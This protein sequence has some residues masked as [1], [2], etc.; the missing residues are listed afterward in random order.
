MGRLPGY[1]FQ[2]TAT[3][4]DG[5]SIRSRLIYAF[6]KRTEYFLDCQSRDGDPLAAETEAGCDQITHSFRL[7]S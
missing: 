5:T 4:A 2:I 6:R 7:G 1:R 3:F